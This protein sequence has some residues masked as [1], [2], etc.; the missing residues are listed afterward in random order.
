MLKCLECDEQYKLAELLNRSAE[1]AKVF[2]A[3]KYKPNYFEEE[4]GVIVIKGKV[5]LV[6]TNV[7]EEIVYD[8]ASDVLRAM[9]TEFKRLV[10]GGDENECK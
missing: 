3:D 1:Y 9:Q 5:M 6:D 2:V 10:L 7:V 8:I 4:Y